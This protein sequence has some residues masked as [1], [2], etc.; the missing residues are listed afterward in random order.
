MRRVKDKI[1]ERVLNLHMHI[2]HF[3]DSST[4]LGLS[5]VF[6]ITSI[7]TIFLEGPLDVFANGRNKIAFIL[8]DE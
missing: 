2:N 1:Y 4:D 6:I 5:L 3:C 8:P 7:T